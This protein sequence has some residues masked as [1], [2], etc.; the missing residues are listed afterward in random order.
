MLQALSTALKAILDAATIPALVR[1]ADVSF[2][3][4][5]DTF[6]PQNTTIN[7]FLYDIRENT[8]LRSNEPV[9]ERLNG[10]VSLRQPS[11]R[12][13]CSYL[14]TV[15]IASGEVGEAAMLKQHQLLAEVLRVFAGL[16][17]IP[18][19]LLSGTPLASQ[20][21]P[22]TLVNLQSELMRNPAEFWSALGG[23]LRPSFTLTATI[24]LDA[25]STP[26]SA[27]AVSS[28]T[29]TIEDTTS[30]AE[31]ILHQIGGTVRSAGN[32]TPV[33]QVAVS[34]EALGLRIL[35]DAD[36]RFRFGGLDAGI[37]AVTFAKS[38]YSTVTRSMQVP[39]V[40]PTAFDVD[41]S[42]AP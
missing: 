25:L 39:G 23:K 32:R 34:I 24:A 10:L 4:P 17:T 3:R 2:D 21:Y 11:Q 27:K 42:L 20:P 28:T 29:F 31:V 19:A 8:E 16:P 36:G 6:N 18:P 35:T 41:L 37:A 12:V 22:I 33:P 14:V 38:G 5:S 26:V 13:A 7:L 1:N 40:T 15:W 9:V 30:S